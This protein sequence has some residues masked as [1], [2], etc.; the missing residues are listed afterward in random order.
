MC[1]QIRGE[2][3]IALSSLVERIHD[4]AIA[5]F[6]MAAVTLTEPELRQGFVR[7]GLTRV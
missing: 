6:N 5:R 2:N 7:D 1:S 3:G 4:S